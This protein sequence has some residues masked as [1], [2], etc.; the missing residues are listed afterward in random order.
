ETV[1]QEFYKENLSKR[2]SPDRSENYRTTENR[3]SSDRKVTA[4]A[5]CHSQLLKVSKLIFNLLNHLYEYNANVK[6]CCSNQEVIEQ[7]ERVKR[8]MADKLSDKVFGKLSDK[9][10]EK[11]F[12]ESSEKSSEKVFN[13]S[14]EKSSE[15]VSE[16]SSKKSSNEIYEK[17]SD[18][19]DNSTTKGY[20]ITTNTLVR[21]SH[22]LKTRLDVLKSELFDAKQKHIDLERNINMA[23]GRKEECLR[24]I[25]QRLS[26]IFKFN[27]AISSQSITKNMQNNSLLKSHLDAMANLRKE[28]S[29]NLSL[30]FRSL[31]MLSFILIDLSTLIKVLEHSIMLYHN[32]KLQAVNEH[33]YWLWNATYKGDIEGVEVICTSNLDSNGV[34]FDYNTLNLNSYQ[35]SN[36]DSDVNFDRE[37]NP[38][39]R[40]KNSSMKSKNSVKN[41]T[42]VITTVRKTSA[43]NYK[44]VMYRNG[45]LCDIRGCSSGQRVLLCI[46]FRISLALCFIKDGFLICLDEPTTNLDSSN[47]QSLATT[48]RNLKRLHSLQLIV[49]THDEEF[50][51]MIR[52]DYVEYYWRVERGQNGNVIRKCGTLL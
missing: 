52:K 20:E 24:G 43:L 42:N 32:N 39:K 49:I 6:R 8:A 37:P 35:D 46:L 4:C 10:S 2:D 5:G 29:K 40:A 18:R 12:N 19:I 51:E 36:L 7:I 28:K 26:E 23:N 38:V 44:L 27:D 47:V 50:V 9:S 22:G 30:L 41:N 14:S 17:S 16:K 34:N 11:V 45:V 25:K 48:I 15:K 21:I 31:N 13:E 3:I 1:F 33:L